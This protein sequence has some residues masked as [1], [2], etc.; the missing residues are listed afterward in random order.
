[1][2]TLNPD[3]ARRH[4]PLRPLLAAC[5]AVIICV[6]CHDAEAPTSREVVAV[7]ECPAVVD[8]RQ[9]GTATGMAGRKVPETPDDW[10]QRRPCDSER[11]EV[12]IKGACFMP[13]ERKPPCRSSQY[14]WQGRC[15]AAIAKQRRPNTSINGALGD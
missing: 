15:F 13:L 2:P 5:L 14:E 11:D 7:V 1:M 4:R 10:M 9:D 3:W 6:W 12:E 8:V